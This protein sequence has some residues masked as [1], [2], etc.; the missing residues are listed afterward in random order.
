MQLKDFSL[1]KED[2]DNYHIGHPKGR[3]ISFPKKGLSDKAQLLISRLKKQQNFDEGTP[4][5]TE[6]AP[7]PSAQE[8]ANSQGL[9]DTPESI[10]ADAQSQAPNEMTTPAETELANNSEQEMPAAKSEVPSESSSAA[11]NNSEGLETAKSSIEKGVKAEQKAGQE[12]AKAYREAAQAQ[13]ILPTQAQVLSAHNEKDQQLQKAFLDK[14]IDPNRY[15]HNMNTGSKIST[16]IAMVLGGIGSGLTGQPN[17]AAQFLQKAID[18]DVEAQKNDQSKT[19]NLWKMNREATGDDLQANLATQN[20]LLSIAKVKALQ[21]AAGAQGP[22]AQQRAATGIQALDQQIALNNWV[23]SRSGNATPGTEQQHI[24]DLE[25]LRQVNPKLRDEVERKYIPGVGVARIAPTS[26]QREELMSYDTIGHRLNEAENFARTEAGTL[27]TFPG[28]AANAKAENI[29]NSLAVELNKLYGLNR[30]TDNEYHNFKSQIPDPGSFFNSRALKR[31]EDLKG[32][33]MARQKSVS[34]QLGVT[35]F[36]KPPTDATAIA[37]ARAN[38]N[39]P[40]SAK[41]LQVASQGIQ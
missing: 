13:E 12:E 35:P 25:T 14:K 33:L 21:A 10:T 22:L 4:D 7:S 40:N 15:L 8:P 41:I 1:L 5:G 18:D 19:L 29:R 20:Q 9:E 23:R 11:P 32:Q 17:V 24:A 31:I 37:W 34:N 38:P 28:S 2:E 6:E 3:S 26:A 30:L 36:K 39:N 27:G 16:A